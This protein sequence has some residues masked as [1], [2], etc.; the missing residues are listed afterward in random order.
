MQD[1][2]E[3]TRAFVAISPIDMVLLDLQ[4]LIVEASPGILARPEVS[5]RASVI[6]KS[7]DVF[8]ASYG[9][10][11]ET[12]L[13]AL[14]QS[15]YVSDLHRVELAD[16]AERWVRA[17]A[18]RWTNDAGQLL[19][20][21]VT[22]QDVTNE[23]VAQR[24]RQDSEAQLLA[25]VENMP[26]SITVFDA[27]TNEIALLN[28]RM[29][30]RATRGDVEIGQSFFGSMSRTAAVEAKAL[31][32]ELLELG[33]LDAERLVTEGPRAGRA[34]RVVARTFTNSHGR[35][36]VLWVA[37][38]VSALRDARDALEQAAAAANAA[39]RAKSEFLANMSHEL[40]TPLNGV[41]GVAGA[42]SK[43]LLSP[44]QV[45]MV[46][47]IEGS[48]KTLETLLSDILDLARIEAGK[49]EV[50]PE[51][52]DL[53]RS[54]NACSALY[55]AAAQA[56]GLDLDV[57]IASDAD[58]AYVGDAARIRQILSN[59]L[60]NAVKFTSAGRV[61]LS[62]QARRGETSSEL[63]FEVGDTGIGF[64]AET[65]A[66]LFS[67]FEQADGSITRRFGGSGLGLSISRSLAEAMGGDLQA[68]AEPGRGAIFTFR[69]ELP[70]CEGVH[71]LWDDAAPPE[72]VSDPLPGMRVLLAEDHPT[73]RRVV[74][75][76]LGA[77]GVALICVENGLQA[78]EAFR[79]QEFDLVLMDMQM[80]VMDGLTAIQEIR[81]IE[82]AEGLPATP[83]YV[84]TANAMP[85]H[86]S[87]SRAAGADGHLTKPIIADVLLE[88]VADVSSGSTRIA[89][90]RIPLL[91][92][93][94]LQGGLQRRN[95][96]ETASNIAQEVG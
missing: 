71:E 78:V 74:E 22:G 8:G 76:I 80:P 50:R 49:M 28:S 70:R 42:L 31:L 4:G 64:D 37:E 68:N 46:S 57:T 36:Q 11:Y 39:N 13:K 32:D 23:Q 18:R 9:T 53:R 61:C 66:R 84:L 16:G 5:G 94:Q 54:V 34:V 82:A 65:K 92:A 86:V 44:P 51:A 52:F 30:D 40:R 29:R 63:C 10:P 41:L 38:D 81:R 21:L 7:L 20:M 33:R 48:A 27:E 89:G 2:A 58:G 25:V 60:S 15:P 87:A 14:E 35:L 96:S 79:R 62:V 24:A 26:V 19:G 3:T 93:E 83:V 75:L 73:N 59:L 43:T 77:A 56:K 55:D 91:P 88:C 47:L 1:R 95:A 12:T 67:R 72:P 45:E 17:H 69:V 6:G 85:E 90:A